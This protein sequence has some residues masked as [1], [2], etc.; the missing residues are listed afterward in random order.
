MNVFFEE[1]GGFKV[2]RVMEDIGTSL[3]VEA[4]T[5]KRSK[6]KANVVLLRFE[7]VLAELLPAAEKLS[8][9]IDPDFLYEVS[10][11][12]E[13]AFDELALDYYGHK[14]SATEAASCAIKLHAAPMYFYKRG[15]GRY[16][17]APAE[18]LKAA[19]AS[20]ER[21]EREA[22]EMA[23]WVDD[24][25]SGAMP[26]ALQPHMNQLLYKPDRNTL[27]AKACDKA[28]ADSAMSLAQLFFNAGAWSQ[29]HHVPHMA[30]HD[31][32]VGKFLTDYFPRGASPK[33][34]VAMS[35]ST[36]LPLANVLAYSID[37]AATTEIDD[38]FSCRTMA[39][40]KIEVGIHI[41]A[42]ALMIA[43]DSALDLYAKSRLSTV[44]YPGHKITML[45]DEAV[46]TATLAEGR[47]VAVISLYAVFAVDDEA[48]A[49]VSTRSVLERVHI[50]KNL[51]LHELETWFTDEAV[52]AKTHQGEFG[53]ECLTLHGIAMAL[54]EARGAKDNADYVDYN[55]D[56]TGNG[57]HVDISA[58]VRG[59]PVDTVVAELM[60]FANSQ[61]GKLLAENNVAA[62]YRVQQNMKTRMTTDALPHEG[63]GVAYYAWSSSPLRRYVDLVN[64]RQLIALIRGDTPHYPRRSPALN[65]I[66]RIFDVTYDAYAE[67]QRNME[68]FW[69]LRYLQQQELVTFAATI[70]REELVRG[71]TLPLIVKLKKSPGLANKTAVTVHVGSIDYWA[72]GGEFSI[73]ETLHNVDSSDSPLTSK[74]T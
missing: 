41:A 47:D 70:I 32:H 52:A 25:L 49:V 24:L 29:H 5:G 43:A 30:Q 1:D 36:D 23:V 39:D 16:Q 58:R 40:G 35:S 44:Y 66:A 74:A 51:R 69:C 48:R 72:I 27:M 20:I 8:A 73:D 64:Q 63:L 15:K 31:F 18:N 62:I 60:I 11:D 17:K 2:A 57:A 21:K 50:Q 4:V 3:Q 68:R 55:F 26:E 53:A 10:G 42:P 56:I 67:F 22:R 45:P 46:A 13:F 65:E 71:A 38:A 37:D 34:D 33:V 6:I 7:S 9:D 59:S 12:A 19:L 54:K 14:P 28:V 61:W